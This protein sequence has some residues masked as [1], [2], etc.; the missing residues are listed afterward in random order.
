MTSNNLAMA[1]P[2]PMT[3]GGIGPRDDDWDGPRLAAHRCRPA[4]RDRRADQISVLRRSIMR[5]ARS[6]L[7]VIAALVALLAMPAAIAA[8][9]IAPAHGATVEEPC[10]SPCPDVPG[11]CGS[12]CIRCDAAMASCR[13]GAGCGTAVAVE[14]TANL[15]SERDGPRSLDIS[16]TLPALHGRSTKPEIHPPSFLDQQA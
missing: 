9:V 16:P 14:P 10:S 15:S 8:E 7:L 1:C 6:F 5:A 2:C 13:A 4:A 11:D 3:S 12:N